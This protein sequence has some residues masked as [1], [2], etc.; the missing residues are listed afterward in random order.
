MH[1]Q[2]HQLAVNSMFR[3]SMEMGLETVKGCRLDVFIEQTNGR[4]YHLV[5]FKISFHYPL[6]LL[7]RFLIFRLLLRIELVVL[8]LKVAVLEVFAD[9]QGGMKVDRCSF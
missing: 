3:G 5:I 9:W 1:L 7:T 8:N 4:S 2:V 6:E